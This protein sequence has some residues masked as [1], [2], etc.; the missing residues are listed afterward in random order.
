MP[1]FSGVISRNC[2]FFTSTSWLPHFGSPISVFRLYVVYPTG[3]ANTF[4][5][6]LFGLS[7]SFLWVQVEFGALR[8]SQKDR[9][10]HTV[11]RRRLTSSVSLDI[12]I[13]MSTGLCSLVSPKLTRSSFHRAHCVPQV[14]GRVQGWETVCWGVLGISLF[15]NTKVTTFPFHVYDRYEIL[16]QYVRDVI[17]HAFIIFLCPTS[18][19]L[20]KWNT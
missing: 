16:I 20:I 10:D 1:H 13:V 12:R 19:N 17:Q 15:E 5:S 6:N 9:T 11:F 14:G 7:F 3:S 4:P 2:S 18:Q 8:G